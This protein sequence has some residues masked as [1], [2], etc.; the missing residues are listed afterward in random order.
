MGCMSEISIDSQNIFEGVIF[1]LL[2][3]IEKEIQYMIDF[4][5]EN[6]L[7]QEAIIDA[8]I[9]LYEIYQV[10]QIDLWDRN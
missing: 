7:K 8:I 3:K 5:V 1:S 4:E 6:K 9:R 2:E 10:I